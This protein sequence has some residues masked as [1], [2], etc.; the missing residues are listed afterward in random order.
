[1]MGN[2]EKIILNHSHVCEWRAEESAWVRDF[3]NREEKSSEKVTSETP[4]KYSKVA[5]RQIN[6]GKDNNGEQQ[7]RI[8]I[9]KQELKGRGK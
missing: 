1:M 7:R 9:I 8:E 5:E 2:A 6:R 3:L 4:E